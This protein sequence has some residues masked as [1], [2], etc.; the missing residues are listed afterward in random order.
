MISAPCGGSG[1]CL[2]VVNFTD[3]QP[4]VITPRPFCHTPYVR[5]GAVTPAERCSGAF[6][7]YVVIEGNSAIRDQGVSAVDLVDGFMPPMVDANNV[8]I[9]CPER[10]D[11]TVYDPPKVCGVIGQQTVCGFQKRTC[12]FSLTPTRDLDTRLLGNQTLFYVSVD[13]IGNVNFTTRIINVIDTVAP[14]IRLNISNA[15]LCADTADEWGCTETD[16]AIETDASTEFRDPGAIATDGVEGRKYFTLL[17]RPESRSVGYLEL[18]NGN[19][20]GVVNSWPQTLR[21]HNFVV[22]YPTDV[23]PRR[24]GQ[25]LYTPK[26]R[27]EATDS[28]GNGGMV[29][30]LNQGLD[31]VERS[32]LIRD[33][34]GPVTTLLSKCYSKSVLAATCARTNDTNDGWVVYVRGTSSYTPQAPLEAWSDP[35]TRQPSSSRCT[36]GDINVFQSISLSDCQNQCSADSNCGSIQWLDQ[37]FLIGGVDQYVEHWATANDAVDSDT[38]SR[39]RRRILMGGPPNEPPRSRSSW[40]INCDDYASGPVFRVQPAKCCGAERTTPQVAECD[41][42]SQNEWH[43]T[44]YFAPA[45]TQWEIQ[46][47]AS[48]VA[49]NVGN[50]V[51]RIVAIIDPIEPVIQL[52]NGEG[53]IFATE[54]GQPYFTPNATVSDNLDTN[55][56]F[57][58]NGKVQMGIESCPGACGDAARL[59]VL[60]QQRL[61]LPAFT[62]VNA[63]FTATDN[64]GNRAEPVRQVIVVKD[65]RLPTLDVRGGAAATHMAATVYHGD[66]TAEDSLDCSTGRCPG[67][68]SFDARYSSRIRLNVQ[69]V[70]PTCDGSTQYQYSQGPGYQVVCRLFTECTNPPQYEYESAAPTPTSDRVCSRTTVCQAGEQVLVTPTNFSDR[71]CNTCA[72]S[73]QT[74]ATQ[75]GGEYRLDSIPEDHVGFCSQIT[76][77]VLLQAPGISSFASSLVVKAIQPA[78]AGHFEWSTGGSWAATDLTGASSGLYVQS[79]TN[80]RFVPAPDFNGQV[81]FMVSR[82]S[83]SGEQPGDVVSNVDTQGSEVVFD[84]TQVNDTPQLTGIWAGWNSDEDPCVPR[85]ARCIDPPPASTE[86]R[87]LICPEP[88]TECYYSDPDTAD[89]TRAGVVVVGADEDNG[90]WWYHCCEDASRAQEEGY[91][92]RIPAAVVDG[93]SALLLDGKCIIEFRP[94]RDFNTQVDTRAGGLGG[95]HEPTISLRAWDSVAAIPGLVENNPWSGTCAR[96]PAYTLS[97]A[98]PSVLNAAVPIGNEVFDAILTIFNIED[99]PRIFGNPAYNFDG[100]IAVASV[101]EF[102]IGGRPFSP[103]DATLP[104]LIFNPD[105]VDITG[106]TVDDLDAADTFTFQLPNSIQVDRSVPGRF[107]FT[108]FGAA[109]LSQGSMDALLRSMR[110][111]PPREST[112]E[113]KNI[114]LVI[115]TA[116]D[117]ITTSFRVQPRLADSPPEVLQTPPTTPLNDQQPFTRIIVDDDNNAIV[118]AQIILVQTGGGGGVLTGLSSSSTVNMSISGSQYF[119]QGN[120]SASVYQSILRGVTYSGAYPATVRLSVFDGQSESVPVTLFLTS[121]ATYTPVRI[122]LELNGT[123][124]STA[125]DNGARVVRAFQQGDDFVALAPPIET[126]VTLVAIPNSVVFVYAEIVNAYDCPFEYLGTGALP[127]GL[128]MQATSVSSVLIKPTT[129]AG[130]T[131]EAFVAAIQSLR[132]MN[133]ADSPHTALRIVNITVVDTQNSSA[134]TLVA[135]SIERSNSAPTLEDHDGLVNLLVVQDVPDASNA[136]MS[137]DELASSTTAPLGDT[138]TGNYFT[139][140]CGSAGCTWEDADLTCKAQAATLCSRAQIIEYLPRSEHTGAYGWISDAFAADAYDGYTVAPDQVDLN[141]ILLDQVTIGGIAVDIPRIESNGTSSEYES[142]DAPES[143]F[144]LHAFRGS[145]TPRFFPARKT[146][147]AVGTPLSAMCCVDS[148]LQ[149]KRAEVAIQRYGSGMQVRGTITIEQ[150]SPMHAAIVQ[151]D[152]RAQEYIA[153][154]VQMHFDMEHRISFGELFESAQQCAGTRF[155]GAPFL[156]TVESAAVDGHAVGSFISRDITLFGINS[157][158]GRSATVSS[159]R[160][161]SSL[162]ATVSCGPVAVRAATSAVVATFSGDTTASVTGTVT[163]T[164]EVGHPEADITI[165]ANLL[166]LSSTSRDWILEQTPSTPECSTFPGGFQAEFR[167]P[168]TGKSVN[169]VSSSALAQILN[170]PSGATLHLKDRIGQYLPDADRCAPLVLDVPTSVDVPISMDNVKGMI[171]FGPG[172]A[173]VSLVMK[174]RPGVPFDIRVAIHQNPFDRGLE[175]TQCTSELVIG[176][177]IIG[178]ALAGGH[179]LFNDGT[180][181][182]IAGRSVRVTFKRTA[183][184]SDETVCATIPYPARP[185]TVVAQFMGPQVT[186]TVTFSQLASGLASSSTALADLQGNSGPLTM[187][188]H[189]GS[190]PCSC[191]GSRCTTL[192]QFVTESSV[193]NAGSPVQLTFANETARMFFPGPNDAPLGVDLVGANSAIGKTLQLVDASGQVVA[194]ATLKAVAPR[195]G[196][197]TITGIARNATYDQCQVLRRTASRAGAVPEVCDSDVQAVLTVTQDTASSDPVL[198]LQL[199]GNTSIDRWY[200]SDSPPKLRVSDDGSI[201]YDC[202]DAQPYNPYGVDDAGCLS[203][204]SGSAQWVTADKCKAGDIGKASLLSGLSC[205]A[206]T[207]SSQRWRCSH[208]A[209]GAAGWA[210]R[211]DR[212]RRHTETAVGLF[213]T[214]SVMGRALVIEQTIRGASV[215][216][217]APILPPDADADTNVARFAD[218]AITGTVTLRQS[219]PTSVAES[220]IEVDVTSEAPTLQLRLTT[221]GQYTSTNTQG[222]GWP[223][224][225]QLTDPDDPG[226]NASSLQGSDAAQVRLVHQ[227]GLW[228]SLNSSAGFDTV[229]LSLEGSPLQLEIEIQWA[230][231]PTVQARRRIRIDTSCSRTS[232]LAVGMIFGRLEITRTPCREWHIARSCSASLS[233]AINPNAGSVLGNCASSGNCALG[234]LGLRLGQLRVPGV[235]VFPESA[236][237]FSQ[238]TPTRDLFVVVEEQGGAPVCARLATRSASMFTDVD[239]Q[240]QPGLALVGLNSEHGRFQV[241][242]GRGGWS[243]VDDG[244]V[245]RG[246]ALLLGAGLGNRIRFVPDANFQGAATCGCLDSP[247]TGEEPLAFQSCAPCILNRTAGAMSFVTWDGSNLAPSGV[248]VDARYAGRTGAYSEFAKQIPVQ[249]VPATANVTAVNGSQFTLEYTVRDNAGNAAVAESVTLEIVDTTPPTISLRG[250]R[251]MDIEAG[252]FFEDP[253]ATAFDAR[254]LDLTNDVRVGGIRRSTDG[255][256]SW[257]DVIDLDACGRTAGSTSSICQLNVQYE[258]TYTVSDADA[259][260]ASATRTVTLVDNTPPAVYPLVGETYEVA[261][262]EYTDSGGRY[263]SL[264]PTA[265]CLETRSIYAANEIGELGCYAAVDRVLGD[266]TAATQVTIHKFQPNYATGA[267]TWSESNA[268]YGPARYGTNTNTNE[269][270]CL[271]RRNLA[272]EEDEFDCRGT[273]VT[274][275]GPTAFQLLDASDVPGTRFLFIFTTSDTSR[276][277]GVTSRM[278]VVMDTVA[279]TLLLNGRQLQDTD[280]LVLDYWARNTERALLGDLVAYDER[281]FPDMRP[282]FTQMRYIDIEGNANTVSPSVYTIN[283]TIRDTARPPNVNSYLRPVRVKSCD[284]SCPGNGPTF[285]VAITASYSFES[286]IGGAIDTFENHDAFRT[287]LRDELQSPSDINWALFSREETPALYRRPSTAPLMNNTCVCKRLDISSDTVSVLTLEV[288]V[289]C[290]HAFLAY[291]ALKTVVPTITLPGGGTIRAIRAANPTASLIDPNRTSCT[292]ELTEVG[293]TGTLLYT[294]L[295]Q[296]DPNVQQFSN[297]T[298]APAESIQVDADT[299]TSI[300]M[301]IIFIVIGVFVCIGIVWGRTAWYKRRFKRVQMLTLMSREDI[302][303]D[304]FAIPVDLRAQRRAQRGLANVPNRPPSHPF[305]E[306]VPNPSYQALPE[307]GPALPSK[308]RDRTASTA[309]NRDTRWDMDESADDFYDSGEATKAGFRTNNK[310]APPKPAAPPPKQSAT[311]FEETDEDF[312]DSGEATRA[313]FKTNNKDDPPPEPAPPPPPKQQ[314]MFEETDEDFYDSGEAT[315]A[316]F[317][318]NNK[319]DPPPEPA[320]PPPPK[321]Q[322]TFEATEEDFYDSGDVVKAGFQTNSADNP[323]PSAA[324]EESAEDFYDSGDVVKAG[325]QTNSAPAGGG[326]DAFLHGQ[327][328][329]NEAEEKLTSAGLKDGMFLVRTRGDMYALSLCA[330]GQFEHHVLKSEGGS[331]TLNGS[332]L[333]KMCPTLPEAIALLASQHDEQVATQLTTPVGKATYNL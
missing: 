205:T 218:D 189:S 143:A 137:I 107:I 119:L 274:Q 122:E 237:Y 117:S 318:T 23:N 152:L 134:T 279:P 62:R 46:Y 230:Q 315:R 233:E 282:A 16:T 67:D 253:G 126:A 30:R 159:Q 330:D 49:G 72:G 317:K 201:E 232:P 193:D 172:G 27:Y 200:I 154:S 91:F 108:A 194:H 181:L 217:C 86:V 68:Y 92:R 71:V 291:N 45:G 204:S 161:G 288:T 281:A 196:R 77:S 295:D 50:V 301:I 176:P 262:L 40:Q 26:V 160:T 268:N 170:S 223:N 4:P 35:S 210:Q 61:G 313:G 111:A 319:D 24:T 136:G 316:G 242:L 289:D 6:D 273:P 214:T 70:V 21:Q 248:F 168:T 325:F 190:I 179:A 73:F 94:D 13:R 55:E 98:R 44:N 251:Q 34:V 323:A 65:S 95:G 290:E 139:A 102:A 261:G 333:A 147:Q 57:Q 36:V 9:L 287:Q 133:V 235:A 17:G 116:L 37:T 5:D 74:S 20:E 252:L 249:M 120:S 310:D 183:G 297:P 85:T 286:A 258:L 155:D 209:D 173:T 298:E 272:T 153:T 125:A 208:V 75:T 278:V 277:T 255:G 88:G 28:T 304:G 314:A 130:A 156:A 175:A 212:H 164:Q 58:N 31:V 146:D 198:D 118:A 110:Y 93:T 180:N 51:S 247:H 11:N 280:E 257:V 79:G 52:V 227:V 178:D 225:W 215:R 241:Q 312:Y 53:D 271:I 221:A 263:Q 1:P 226:A 267:A 38:T 149:P 320:P 142:V 231:S 222:P 321:Q 18:N 234:A 8:A 148:T 331:F 240:D 80:L 284:Q 145:Q 239:S 135:V 132:Y 29:S 115:D 322:A 195:T 78:A 186:G 101:V 269:A 25:T 184:G 157:V 109:P 81:T 3:T 329:R 64:S 191:A 292:T 308:A 259:N 266:S 299:S 276:N 165:Y 177:P 63:T 104:T 283:Y 114:D 300:T 285:G 83:A 244:E 202:G 216:L 66:V 60:N 100:T 43:E 87:T 47:F 96:L 12:R 151:V 182:G 188:V 199:F 254:Q 89:A 141:S 207:G 171:K 41:P 169:T 211:T 59:L 328:S 302:Y 2:K 256:T 39:V 32:I 229:D 127:A 185:T 167:L 138:R 113:A 265:D 245:T 243:D 103:F 144:V 106:I 162:A 236:A 33:E 309:S 129:S 76:F 311:P 206:T 270:R 105:H 90:K 124:V 56:W 112:N 332:P 219:K 163:F 228:Y 246:R 174:E 123:E 327:L 296:A 14:T 203:S 150:L 238:G 260:S 326:T 324:F 82:Y 213:G 19:R 42:H 10:N 306:Q 307:D 224:G 54:G 128:T 7:R 131:N 97:D 294:Y 220:V 192:G 158:V 99:T 48:D 303:Q 250:D 166:D 22:E 197:A 140:S 264:T 187:R 69:P 121:S 84:V 15:T 275:T 305:P 293:Y